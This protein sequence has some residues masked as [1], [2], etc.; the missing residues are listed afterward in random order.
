MPAVA[1]ALARQGQQRLTAEAFHQDCRPLLAVLDEC[2]LDRCVVAV[3][4]IITDDEARRFGETL[5]QD[6]RFL[7]PL[8]QDLRGRQSDDAAVAALPEAL[9][10][11]WKESLHEAVSSALD[12]RLG[13]QTADRP[14]TPGQP[15]QV[16]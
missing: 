2:G 3:L 15:A 13:V 12:S 14:A 4:R 1:A 8:I 6:P 11:W 7:L 9:D 10:R 5:V 16:R